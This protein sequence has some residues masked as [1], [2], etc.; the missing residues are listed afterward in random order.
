MTKF[1]LDQAKCT[2]RPSASDEKPTCLVP[3]SE[4]ILRDCTKCEYKTFH[5]KDFIRQKKFKQLYKS[6]SQ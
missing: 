4:P 3:K 6:T 5:K 1:D 2:S